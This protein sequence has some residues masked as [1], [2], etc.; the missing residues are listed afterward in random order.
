MNAPLTIR[1]GLREGSNYPSPVTRVLALGYYDGPTDGVFQCGEGG[2]VYKFDLVEG[3]FST[4][5][6]LWEMR[7]FSVASLPGSAL[8]RLTE[9]YSRFWPPHWPVW[10]PTWHFPDPADEQ[11]MRRLTDEVLREAGPVEWVVATADLLGTIRAARPVT[12]GELSGVSDWLAF[13]GIENEAPP[14]A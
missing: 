12:A 5:D 6:G 3:P 4:E 1:P 10:V 11:A 13:L 14:R 8:A 9:A 7:V 2:P